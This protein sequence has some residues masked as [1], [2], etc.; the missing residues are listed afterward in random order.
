MIRQNPLARTV[1]RDCGSTWVAR[2]T[3]FLCRSNGVARV[4]R[5]WMR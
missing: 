1:E 5:Q 2:E 4:E 3:L